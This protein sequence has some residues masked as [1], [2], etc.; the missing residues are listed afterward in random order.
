MVGGTVTPT[1]IKSF[2]EVF[3]EQCPVYM[4]I[5]MTYDEFWNG[6]PRMTEAYRKA[7]ELKQDEE[8][9]RLWLQGKYNY[10]AV[11]TALSNE[12]RE[13]GKKA[14][15][16]LKEPILLR[17]QTE[18][19]LEAEQERKKKALIDKLTS[20]QQKWVAKHKKGDTEDG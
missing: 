5:G 18:K 16:Y 10:I 17:P 8:N 3:R 4:S 1:E 15:D 12:F 2:A 19:E 14:D 9:F 7:H 6:T 13:K 11:G 20:M